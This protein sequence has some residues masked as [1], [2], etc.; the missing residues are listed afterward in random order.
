M[1]LY[2]RKGGRLK[3]KYDPTDVMHTRRVLR[4]RR[5]SVQGW[6]GSWSP[7]VISSFYNS[8]LNTSFAFTWSRLEGTKGIS[9]GN[10]FC[11]LPLP[12]PGG[13]AARPGAPHQRQTSIDRI[14]AKYVGGVQRLR[15]RHEG[16]AR[17][18]TATSTRSRPARL[19]QAP[20]TTT[21]TT[22]RPAR[23]SHSRP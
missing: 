23:Y 14:D 21:S 8:A 16:P 15:A 2:C 5:Y 17:G 13:R 3:L 18:Q 6:L 20:D 1:Q 4:T 11:T 9:V 7:C 22:R 19:A 12:A 10:D